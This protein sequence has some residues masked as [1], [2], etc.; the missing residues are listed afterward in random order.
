MKKEIQ[1]KPMSI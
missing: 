1:E